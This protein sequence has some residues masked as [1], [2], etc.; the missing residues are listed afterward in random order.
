MNKQNRDEIACNAILNSTLI[1]YFSHISA[2][3]RGGIFRLFSQWN[4]KVKYFDMLLNYY[5]VSN[6]SLKNGYVGINN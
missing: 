2:T 3:Y 1:F 5:Q 4:M 6:E